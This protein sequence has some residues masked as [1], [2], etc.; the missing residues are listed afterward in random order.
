MPG[1]AMWPRFI[2]MLKPSGEYASRITSTESWSN[3]WR[4]TSSGSDSAEKSAPWRRGITITWPELYGYLFSIT[5]DDAV[6]ATIRFFL[7]FSSPVSAGK[8]QKMQPFG[9]SPAMNS[10]R[11]GAQ[12]GC[13]ASNAL[14]AG[15]GRGGQRRHGLGRIAHDGA[16][17]R[18]G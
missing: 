7:S 3:R 12:I 6:R 15:G 2:P 18:G 16:G 5:N 11:Q 1:P 13:I 10:M 14:P 17:R 9:F 4:S 8:R